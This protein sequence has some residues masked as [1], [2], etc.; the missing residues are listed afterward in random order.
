[1]FL[2][3]GKTILG[4]IV[5]ILDYLNQRSCPSVNEVTF[6]WAKSGQRLFLVEKSSPVQHLGGC[7]VTY[8]VASGSSVTE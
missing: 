3:K 4:E 1:M 8:L 5:L 7:L 6:I 2:R